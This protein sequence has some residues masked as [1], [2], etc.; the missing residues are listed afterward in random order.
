MESNINPNA[1]QEALSFEAFRSSVIADYRVALTSREV[2][3]LGRR[4]VLTG[5]AKFGIFWDGKEIPQVA[6]IPKIIFL[7]CMLM[8]TMTPI[9]GVK[10]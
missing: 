1:A 9:A 3:L 5:K 7:N 2:S 6:L 10:I 8:F 4:E